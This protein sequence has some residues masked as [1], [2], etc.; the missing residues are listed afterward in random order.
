M[1]KCYLY[2]AMLSIA[3][4]LD[5]WGGDAL[6]PAE[7]SPLTVESIEAC[8]LPTETPLTKVTRQRISDCLGWDEKVR[9]GLCRGRYQDTPSFSSSTQTE[10]SADEVSFYTEGESSLRGHVQVKT[11]ERVV[12]AETAKLYR[13]AKTKRI[14]HIEL[15]DHVHLV[16]KNRAIW[17]KKATIDPSTAAGSIQQVLYRFDTSFRGASLPAWGRASFVRRFDNKNLFLKNATYSTC[18]PKKRDWQIEARELKLDE[19]RQ[20]GVARDAKL[21]V[22]DLPIVYMPYFSFPTTK[23][24]KTGFLMPMYGYSNIGGFDFAAPYYVNLAPNYDMT[25]TP[26]AYTLRGVMLNAEG[27]YLT[28]NSV[29]ML[30][31]SLLPDD[32][33]YRKFLN[34][35]NAAFP[36]LE[37]QSNNRW[38]VLFRDDTALTDQ[39]AMHVNFQQVSDN[40]YLQDFSSNLAVLTENQLRKEGALIYTSEHWQLKGLA[41]AYQTLNPINQADVSHIYER[42]PQF[43]AQGHYDELPWNMRF[44]FTGEFDQFQWPVNDNTVPEGPRFHVNPVL[45]IDQHTSWGYVVPQAQLINNYYHLSAEGLG[46]TTSQNYT[47][48]RYSV[49]SGLFFEDT[50]TW[51]NHTQTL[52]PRL[53]YLNVPYYNQSAVPAFD[54]AYM[55][56]SADQLFRMN[57]FSGQDRIGDTNQLTYALTTRFLKHNGIEQARFTAGQITYFSDRKVNLCYNNQG[58]CEDNPLML[59]YLSPTTRTSPIATQGV[60]RLNSAWSAVGDW[61]FD[62]SGSATNNADLN[63]HYQPEENHLLRFG[64]SYLV[65]GNIF[66]GRTNEVGHAALHQATAGYAWPLSSE[67]SGL[68]VYGYNLSEH[69]DMMAFLGFQYDSCCWAVRFLGGRVYN[70]LSPST[71]KPEYNNNVYIQ[72]LLKG[73]GTVGSSDPASTI[74][75]YLPGYVN[76]FQH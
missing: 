43:T 7:T 64:Y 76:Q 51:R 20:E 39:L 71:L 70:S 23:A 34:N 73:L 37:Q 21:R 15:L 50:A 18:P 24:R 60:Y 58:V 72:L 55:I 61:V 46:P 49:D 40:Y 14:T 4:T 30:N 52:E 66:S 17:A 25:I 36:G 28:S 8:V 75:S 48:P 38:S 47:V 74:Q 35:N 41:E 11:P 53:F 54:S 27:R 31:A 44:G 2:L 10:L 63:F 56:F 26:R 12:T 69:Y 5:A 32:K 67:W 57:R 1:R 19:A 13:D 65:N 59:G 45:A 6:P 62:P 16:E 68:G 3:C 29:G 42:L 22:Y 33:A 9:V